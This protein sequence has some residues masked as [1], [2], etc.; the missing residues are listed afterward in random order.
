MFAACISTQKSI[1]LHAFRAIGMP[2][3]IF[4]SV[5]LS[6]FNA[7]F[8]LILW[9]DC[10]WCFFNFH[11]CF[12]NACSWSPFFPCWSRHLREWSQIAH[13]VIKE[14]R[15]R[16]K[17]CNCPKPN[18]MKW[19]NSTFQLSRDYNSN[20]KQPMQ[21]YKLTKYYTRPSAMSFEVYKQTNKKKMFNSI[22]S[23]HAPLQSITQTTTGFVPILKAFMNRRICC[24]LRF[25]SFR[26]HSPHFN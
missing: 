10:D 15:T 6:D 4:G 16:T 14:T 22:E 25:T 1:N 20:R 19:M 21:S 12:I 8:F 9:R 3:A 17:L 5:Q 7:R 23:S 18:A 24:L 26:F 13:C 2:K 11:T